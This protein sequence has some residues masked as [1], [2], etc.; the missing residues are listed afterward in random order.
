MPTISALKRP[1]SKLLR[2][3]LT[4]L[5]YTEKPCLK[6]IKNKEANSYSVNVCIFL[7]G[8]CF[9]EAKKSTSS[10]PYLAYTV[11]YDT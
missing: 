11:A 7:T 3:F 6:Q 5:S 4:S 1:R 10:P 9:L 2:E 8:K